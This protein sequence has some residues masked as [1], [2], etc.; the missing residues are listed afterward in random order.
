MLSLQLRRHFATLGARLLV[1]TD[2]KGHT[3]RLAIRSDE[4]GNYFELLLPKLSRN[5]V[6]VLA[7]RPR[8]K[9]LLLQ[10]AHGGEETH[11]IVKGGQQWSIRSLA[12]DE[13]QALVTRLPQVDATPTA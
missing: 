7:I 10:L 12:A 4:R 13:A 3:T 5:N 6:A 11:L 2:P 9:R 1:R 8:E